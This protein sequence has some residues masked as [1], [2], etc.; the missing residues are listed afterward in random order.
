MFCDIAWFPLRKAAMPAKRTPAVAKAPTIT[1]G[2]SSSHRCRPPPPSPSPSR[3]RPWPRSLRALLV[4]LLTTNA[5]PGKLCLDISGKNK[6]EKNKTHKPHKTERASAQGGHGC[7]VEAHDSRGPP[8]GGPGPAL[9]EGS[10]QGGGPGPGLQGARLTRPRHGGPLHQGNPQITSPHNIIC[11]RLHSRS[12]PFSSSIVFFVLG[13]F[14]TCP[15]PRVP[16][17]LSLSRAEPILLVGGTV[18]RRFRSVLHGTPRS[19]YEAGH[20]GTDVFPVRTCELVH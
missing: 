2:S 9:Q 19:E 11:S 16:S 13:F 8:E 1:K 4:K 20:D 10:R 5:L 18:Q 3:S 17:L 6:L 15:D 7:C 12:S 14:R